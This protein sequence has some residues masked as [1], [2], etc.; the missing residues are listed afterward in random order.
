M[1]GVCYSKPLPSLYGKRDARVGSSSLISCNLSRRLSFCLFSS[2]LCWLRPQ[3]LRLADWI[4][5]ISCLSSLI[6]S[7]SA[8]SFIWFATSG[9]RRRRAGQARGGHGLRLPLLRHDYRTTASSF[10]S[11]LS[12]KDWRSSCISETPLDQTAGLE[13]VAEYQA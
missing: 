7:I 4:S 13:V 10:A 5:E 11:G 12:G 6:R 1:V 2:W 8:R 3:Y 9:A